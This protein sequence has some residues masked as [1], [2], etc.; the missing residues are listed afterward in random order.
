MNQRQIRGHALQSIHPRE[1]SLIYS[2][3]IAMVLLR[4]PQERFPSINYQPSGLPPGDQTR[5]KPESNPIKVNQTKWLFPS[6]LG[7]SAGEA[8]SQNSKEPHSFAFS[9]LRLPA[10]LRAAM[11]AA[12]SIIPSPKNLRPSAKSAD[13]PPPFVFFEFFMVKSLC[14]PPRPPRLHP[15]IFPPIPSPALH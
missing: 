14:L 7:A 12:A 9:C 10:A 6:R 4:S 11:P 13:T 15:H 5:I 3:P 1:V 2:T 8:S